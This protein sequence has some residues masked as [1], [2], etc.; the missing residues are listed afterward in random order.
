MCV[1]WSRNRVMPVAHAE[2]LA[3]LTSGILCYVDDAKVLVMLD[4]PEA[5]AHA[6]GEFLSG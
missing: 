5:T 2:A 1:L 6:I 3:E 4:Q